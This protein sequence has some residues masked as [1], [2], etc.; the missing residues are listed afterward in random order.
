MQSKLLFMFHYCDGSRNLLGDSG[1]DV[2]EER[3]DGADILQKMIKFFEN[4]LRNNLSKQ[5]GTL[6]M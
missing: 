3:G 2:V 5:P 6:Q 1:G 4:L